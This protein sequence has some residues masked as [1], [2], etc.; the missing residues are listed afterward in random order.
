LDPFGNIWWLYEPDPE[1]QN[2]T[3][4]SSNTDWHDKKPSEVYTTIMDAMKKLKAPGEA[5]KA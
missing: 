3:K 1:G 4:Q 5:N 2:D